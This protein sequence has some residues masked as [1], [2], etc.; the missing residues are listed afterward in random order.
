MFAVIFRLA[1]SI[2][3]IVFAYGMGI[4]HAKDVDLLEGGKLVLT[5]GITTIEGS[6]GGGLATWATIARHGDR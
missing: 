6:S 5:N 3:S 4:A 2:G 1:L